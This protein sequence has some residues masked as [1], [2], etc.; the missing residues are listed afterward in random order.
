MDTYHFMLLAVVAGL[1]CNEYYRNMQLEAQNIDITESKLYQ[2]MKK[3]LEA[4]RDQLYAELLKVNTDKYQAEREIYQLKRSIEMEREKLRT[5][6]RDLSHARAEMERLNGC[7]CLC[8]NFEAFGFCT[9]GLYRMA[10]YYIRKF[11][12]SNLLLTALD[13]VFDLLEPQSHYLLIE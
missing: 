1:V 7:T 11:V 10:T 12:G 2:Q 3:S 5:S 13:Y 6:E 4:E 8:S 9:R